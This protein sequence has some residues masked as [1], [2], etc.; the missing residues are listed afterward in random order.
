VTKK[1][2]TRKSRAAIERL[3]A[4]FAHHLDGRDYESLARLFT[5][6][7]EYVSGGVALSGRAEIM[8]RFTARTMVRTTRHTYSGLR[9]SQAGH[10]TVWATSVWVTYAVNA[11][12]PVDQANLYMIADFSDV[13]VYDGGRWWFKSREIIPVFRN[14]QWAPSLADLDQGDRRGGAAMD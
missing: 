13:Y 5:A 3:N 12:A 4:D 10:G 11:V 9:L 1:A 6:D 7:C 2:L 8:G 14:P